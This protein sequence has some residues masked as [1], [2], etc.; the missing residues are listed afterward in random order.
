MSEGWKPIPQ[1]EGIYEVSDLGHVRRTVGATKLAPEAIPIMRSLRENGMT[2][3]AIASRFGISKRGAIVALS[4]PRSRRSLRT[5]NRVLRH[6]IGRGPRCYPTVR[7]CANGKGKTCSVHS[8]VAA[9]LLGP[10]PFG[11]EINHKN[12]VKTDPRLENLEYLTTSKNAEHAHRILGIPGTAQRG[13]QNGCAKLSES[14]VI[15]IRRSYSPG[16]GQLARLARQF[17]VTNTA[18]WRIVHRKTW[19]HI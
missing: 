16:Y 14:D 11:K 18:I 7:L 2:F 3:A 12:G 8:L 13:S 10:R 19:R 1:Y 17:K 9:A 6:C 4:Y 15:Q 5:R